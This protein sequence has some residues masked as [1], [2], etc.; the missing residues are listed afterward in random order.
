MPNI[1]VI[2]VT[3]RPGSA[4]F[5]S[6][7]LHKQAF[8]DFEVILAD[9]ADQPPLFDKQ[10]KPRAKHPTDAW[11]LN[12][13]YNDAVA[14][15]QGDLLVF[16]QDFI[17]IPANGL[18]RFWDVHE[19]FPDDFFTGCGHKA[20]RGL[21]GISEVDDRVFGH[22]GLAPTNF[23]F[24]ELNW[25]AAP[26]ATF[27]SFQEDLDQFYGGENIVIAKKAELSGAHF[28]LDRSNV[29]IG[30]SQ[31][32]CGGRPQDWEARHINKDGRLTRYLQDLELDRSTSE[33]F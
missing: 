26:R 10:F 30:Y 19:L 13:A 17:W 1:S 11:N 18:Q 31:D 2:C 14:Q 9:D 16:L 28:W 27:P 12:K 15:A 21:E 24:W 6:L 20:L 29:C 7:Q 8:Q 33:H 4:A 5:L 23:T 32:F 22:P 3:N 25:A